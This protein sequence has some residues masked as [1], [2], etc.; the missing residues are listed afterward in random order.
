LIGATAR[1][2][3]IAARILGC[4]TMR[5]LVTGPA[6]YPERAATRSDDG[7]ETFIAALHECE[8]LIYDCFALVQI[9]QR[10]PRGARRAAPRDARGG[11]LRL[12]NRAVAR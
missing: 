10:L 5:I 8:P 3:A 1:I 4:K 12:R 11:L 6:R 9:E 2:K 7:F